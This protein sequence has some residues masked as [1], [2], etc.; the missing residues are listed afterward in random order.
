MCTIIIK[1]S[2][3]HQLQ[4]TNIFHMYSNTE[5]QRTAAKMSTG[6]TKISEYFAV[7]EGP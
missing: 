4:F 1:Y 6:Q 5:T 7:N 3:A 2:S